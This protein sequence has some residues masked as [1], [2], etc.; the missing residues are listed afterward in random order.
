ML[1]ELTRSLSA[2]HSTLSTHV[3]HRSHAIGRAFR[4]GLW[5]VALGLGTSTSFAQTA[6]P[7][8]ML[9]EADNTVIS[10]SCT[11]TP[12]VGVLLDA[13]GNGVVHIQ[14][15]ADG[16]PIT[17][18][19]G[20]GLL[21][22]SALSPERLSGV[23]IV[24]TGKNVTLR[25]GKVKGFKVGIRGEGCDGLVLEDFDT[26]DNYAQLL[27]SKPWKENG[28]D[29]LFPHQND[30]GEW[31]G[32]HGAGVSISNAKGVTIRRVTSLRTQNGVL[33]SGVNDSKIY[34]NDCSFL[35]GWGL[36]LWR[37]NRNEI[38]RNNFD[39]CIRGYSNGVYARGQDSAGI[40]MFEQC[41]D[42]LIALNS[43]THS[44]DGIFAFAGREALGEAPPPAS[45]PG[46][47]E[48]SAWYRGRGCNNNRFIGNDLSFSSAHGL[49]L[50]FSFGNQVLRNRFEGNGFCGVWG[51]Y[52]RDT[53][54]A[55]NTFE[56]N[57]GAGHG[58]ERGGIAM[59]HAQGT[60]IEDNQFSLHPQG[61]AIWMDEDASLAKLPWSIANG[62]E[63]KNNR[64]Q[65]NS[66]TKDDVAIALIGTQ[67]TSLDHNQ[68]TEC[69]TE[70]LAE[71]ATDT[72]QSDEGHA[73]SAPTAESIET[74]LAALPGTR[75]AVGFRDALRGRDRIVMLERGPYEWNR[76]IIVRLNQSQSRAQYGLHGFPKM[77][78]AD[79]LGRGP[80]FIG[81]A[82]DDRGAEVAADPAGFVTPYLVQIRAINK[83]KV[84]Y[85]DI[86]APAEWRTRFFALQGPNGTVD[87]TKDSAGFD[88]LAAAGE[89]EFV[90]RE[91]AFEYGA[92]APQQTVN[93]PDVQKLT[94]PSDGFGM[95]AE[96]TLHFIPGKYRIHLESCDAAR[97][98]FDGRVVLDRFNRVGESAITDDA[99]AFEITEEREVPIKVEHFDSAGEAHLRIYFE[100]IDP[101][102][103]G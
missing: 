83:V 55:S 42:N 52:S 59:E 77:V 84:R 14:G 3:R 18:D 99:F 87:P 57:G 29:W 102:I 78:G 53:L 1:H 97:V 76:P 30:A 93:D 46:G 67:A 90:L 24:V 73:S 92:R 31:A 86:L 82:R 103:K 16:K 68:F 21:L 39:F 22:G 17:V 19:F 33:L 89:L 28:A 26:S 98:R 80:L 6:A 7:K 88:A 9:I 2:R 23:G 81:M 44:G 20:G 74:L 47:S 62:S 71:G 50:T 12:I 8:G 11:A 27:Q 91:L 40:L 25:N 15:D 64:I 4:L 95:V 75:K 45:A 79:V 70:L 100:A 63:A 36:A 94:L 72:K 37:S 69:A 54:I 32:S 48:P 13:D 49:E 35:S 101:I 56:G 43:C 10:Q 96:T 41:S 65:S 58:R 61:V 85:L 34:D 51:G 38:A 60:R 66:F 5:T